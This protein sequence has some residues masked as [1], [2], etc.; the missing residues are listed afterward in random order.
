MSG[1][2]CHTS[3]FFYKLAELV[4]GSVTHGAYHL[5]LKAVLKGTYMATLQASTTVQIFRSTLGHSLSQGSTPCCRTLIWP[6]SPCMATQTLY[7]HTTIWPHYYMA[8]QPLAIPVLGSVA[9]HLLVSL[10]SLS[11]TATQATQHHTALACTVLA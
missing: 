10:V 2:T 1:V 6:H 3:H 7:G 5:F 9:G 4:V 11:I 8:T